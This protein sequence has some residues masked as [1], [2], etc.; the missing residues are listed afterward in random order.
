MVGDLLWYHS[1]SSTREAQSSDDNPSIHL[2]SEFI[3]SHI[4][5]SVSSNLNRYIKPLWGESG[6]IFCSKWPKGISQTSQP[7]SW[8][9]L[10]GNKLCLT[11]MCKSIKSGKELVEH[12]DQLL[13]W[14]SCG[15]VGE[16]FNICKKNAKKKRKYNIKIII[17]QSVSFNYWMFQVTF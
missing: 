5:F 11:H 7:W 6:Y 1:L 4:T 15:K 9:C 12:S 17:F 14:Q 8:F 2:L 13:G 3:I 16:S 10:S